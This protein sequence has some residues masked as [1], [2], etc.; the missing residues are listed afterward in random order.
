MGSQARKVIGKACFF[1]VQGLLDLGESVLDPKLEQTQRLQAL[2][3]VPLAHFFPG[4]V[5]GVE[6]GGRGRELI[7]EGCSVL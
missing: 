2:C 1:T 4:G 6:W 7:S 3:W 5:G